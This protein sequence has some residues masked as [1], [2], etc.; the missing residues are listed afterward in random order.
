M[1]LTGGPDRALRRY[2]LTRRSSRGFV[3]LRLVD[4]V[5]VNFGA[6]DGMSVV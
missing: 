5:S 6:V 3:W 1:I 2:L 4:F